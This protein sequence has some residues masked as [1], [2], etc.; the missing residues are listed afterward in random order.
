M[1]CLRQVVLKNH[2]R[3]GT[4]VAMN[5]KMQPIHPGR[6][7]IDRSLIF[8]YALSVLLVLGVLS[9]VWAKAPVTAKIAFT[10]NRDGNYEIYIMNPDG[11]GQ[12]NLTRH[13]ASDT[14][15]A[16]SPTGEEILFVSKR[17]GRSDLY[18]M[19]AD[20][21]NVR[22]V[23]K[24]LKLRTAP[25][26]SPDG[27]QISYSRI[28]PVRELYIA[29]LDKKD[30][31]QVAPLGKYDGYSS[32]APDGT[33]IVFGGPSKQEN[34]DSRIYIFNLETRRKKVLFEEAVLT[35]MKNPS[36]SPLDDKI[37]FAWFRGGTSAIYV[38]ERNGDNPERIVDPPRGF[39]AAHPEWSPDGNALVYEQYKQQNNVRHIYIMNLD[40]REPEKLTSK[41][42]NFFADW[43]DPAYALALP[44][45]P[46]PPLLTTT[47]GK[48]KTD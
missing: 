5:R 48:I 37:A 26:W 31:R 44:V 10:S 6:H 41:G 8:S 1:N 16:W 19:D 21:T 45:Q 35:S 3:V 15:P 27:Q 29:S 2:Q 32:W 24:D 39:A 4:H 22:K 33:K 9:S 40:E 28:D 30:E 14:Q 36:W 23:F 42:I 47:W 13:K 20:G 25:A 46:Q 17:D 34:K 38:M 43:F 12:K 18:L 7:T 11:T